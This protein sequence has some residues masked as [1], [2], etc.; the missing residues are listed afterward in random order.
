MNFKERLEN[1]I[2][3]GSDS[4][5]HKNVIVVMKEFGYTIEEIKVMPSTTFQ[6]LLE[7]LQEEAERTQRETEK[8]KRKK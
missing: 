5:V 8:A 6:M 3:K 1:F 7:H 4:E 2:P